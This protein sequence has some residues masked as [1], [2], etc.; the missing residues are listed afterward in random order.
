MATVKRGSTVTECDLKSFDQ[1][2]DSLKTTLNEIKE[3]NATF[4]EFVDEQ[5]KITKDLWNW[6][7]RYNIL[8]A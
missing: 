5:K 4:T 2:L 7:T 3:F 1:F 6:V 8:N